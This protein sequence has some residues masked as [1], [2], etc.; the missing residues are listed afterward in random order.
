VREGW[1]AVAPMLE[2]KETTAPKSRSSA[3]EAPAELPGQGVHTP[4]VQ[5]MPGHAVALVQMPLV[6]KRRAIAKPTWV[7]PALAAARTAER[8][9][10]ESQS[11]AGL[12]LSDAP[13]SVTST[14]FAWAPWVASVA[15]TEMWP[16]NE[17][18]G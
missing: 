18:P 6:R 7:M 4:S 8:A 9:S 14:V 12:Q 10:E 16:T 3:G 11:D 15:E 13:Y 5:Q 17:L 2:T 1:L